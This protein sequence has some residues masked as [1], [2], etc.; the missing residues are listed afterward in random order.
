MACFIDDLI[1][2]ITSTGTNLGGEGGYRAG[3]VDA[4]SAREV[5]EW[6]N[7][8]PG[9]CLINSFFID[10]I[11]M[12]NFMLLALFLLGLASIKSL[13]VSCSAMY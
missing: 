12:F 8:S 10:R 2:S 13:S 1:V 3:S 9:V 4:K 11:V 7:D 6:L 5:E